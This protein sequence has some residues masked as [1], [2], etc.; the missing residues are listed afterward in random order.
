MKRYFLTV[1]WCSKGNRGIFC[2]RDG[3]TFSQ[4]HEHTE[5]EIWEILDS[6]SLILSP[7]SILLTED[8]LKEY[9]RWV[10]LTE[11]SNEYG[12]ALKDS[13]KAMAKV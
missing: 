6:F 11:F 1:D 5:A 3:G 7:Q 2:S 9:H 13:V 8:E 4:E 10:P 12:V